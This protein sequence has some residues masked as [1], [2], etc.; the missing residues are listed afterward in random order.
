MDNAEEL[1]RAFPEIAVVSR[2]C[3]FRSCTH[4]HEP[5]CAVKPAVGKGQIASFRFEDYLQFLSEIE[6]RRETY[7]KIA[8]KQ[9]K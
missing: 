1:N 4:T 9:P 8:K 3:K 7:K 5:N 6:H 2:D